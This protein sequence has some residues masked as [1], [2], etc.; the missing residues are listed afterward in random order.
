MQLLFQFES[1]ETCNQEMLQLNKLKLWLLKKFAHEPE[2]KWKINF[3]Q[4]AAGSL[5][6]LKW[7][8]LIAR[9]V[10]VA[11]GGVAVNSAIAWMSQ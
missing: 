11:R 3:E 8:Q 9:V 6:S 5:D 1:C 10:L 7:Q 4:T 2:F